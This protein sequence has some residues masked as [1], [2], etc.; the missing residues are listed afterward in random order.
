MM[1]YLYAGT[2]LCCRLTCTHC[3]AVTL[4]TSQDLDR[5]LGQAPALAAVAPA[6]ANQGAATQEVVLT[7]AVSLIQTQKSPRKMNLQRLTGLR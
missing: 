4:T 1:L 2:S 6:A 5:A 7:Q 3:V